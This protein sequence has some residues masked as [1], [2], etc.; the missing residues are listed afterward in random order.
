[1]LL[2]ACP[3]PVVSL[4]GGEREGRVLSR[5][6]SSRHFGLAHGIGRSGDLTAQQPKAIGSSLLQ[7]LST[8]LTR[9]ALQLAGLPSATHCLLTPVATGMTL[10]LALLALQSERDSGATRPRYVVLPRID[11]KTCV[12]CITAAGLQ[13]SIVQL[14]TAPHSDALVT[15]VAAVEARIAEL[16][17]PS[18]VL[19]V[20]S[21]TSCFAPRGSDD[22]VGLAVM[23]E[24][25]GVAHL[26]NNAYGVQSRPVMAAIERAGRVGRVDA[27]VQSMDKNFM[28]PV[29][30][31]VVCEVGGAQQQRA[32]HIPPPSQPSGQSGAAASAST[33][34]STSDSTSAPR[35]APRSSLVS[36]MSRLYPGRASSSSLTDLLLT[37]LTLGEAGW[38]SLL[39]KRTALFERL[40]DKLTQLAERHGERVLHTADSNDI[41]IALTLTLPAAGSSESR[42]DGSSAA[43]SLSLL[44]SM[45]YRRGVSGMRV[46]QPGVETPF[47]QLPLHNWGGHGWHVA[48]SRAPDLSSY[49]PLSRSSSERSSSSDGTEVQSGG[50]GDKQSVRGYVSMACAVGMEQEE[51]DAVIEKLDD[52]LKQWRKKFRRSSQAA[53]APPEPRQTSELDL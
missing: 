23:C 14:T 44:G 33:S 35:P 41:S 30:G 25:L 34:D 17:G 19:C 53:S 40:S 36:S 27:V 6:V 9:H 46:W 8:A 47:A 22:V 7:L 11:Q 45:L 10:T 2:R 31:A 15:D 16:G 12:K 32:A 39:S 1:M 37:L 38:L 51:V 13:P 26:V 21:V 28:V 4:G 42:A 5:L 3:L 18:S 50:S 29:G 43:R 52:S 20:M 49:T 48:A 24:R